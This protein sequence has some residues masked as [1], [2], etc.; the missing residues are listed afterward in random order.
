MLH[1]LHWHHHNQIPE[2]VKWL[3]SITPFPTPSH[4]PPFSLN[5]ISCFLEPRPQEPARWSGEQTKGKL[6]S[7]VKAPA[8]KLFGAYLSQMSNYG[9]NSLLWILLGIKGSFL[10]KQQA[11]YYLYCTVYG[12]FLQYNIRTTAVLCQCTIN[13]SQCCGTAQPNIS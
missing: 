7:G 13:I 6:A 1:N 3:P 8:D 10:H 5:S 11:S 9:G 12:A 2:K 4:S